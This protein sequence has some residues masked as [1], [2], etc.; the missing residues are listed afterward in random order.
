MPRSD[1]YIPLRRFGYWRDL[2]PLTGICRPP[3]TAPTHR[4][5]N[6]LYA[7][8]THDL[9]VALYT[10]VYS[11]TERDGLPRIIVPLSTA[12]NPP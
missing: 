6:C 7:P 8:L 4:G 2:H 9:D 10:R 1:I 11:E 12:I 3:L 5:Y